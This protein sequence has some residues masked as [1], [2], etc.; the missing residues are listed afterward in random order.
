MANYTSL[1]SDLFCNSIIFWVVGGGSERERERRRVRT[2]THKVTLS[3]LFFYYL[4]HA[5]YSS[6]WMKLI[7]SQV[8]I[9]IP[10]PSTYSNSYIIL[11]PCLALIGSNDIYH[12][13]K[14]NSIC[15][16]YIYPFLRNNTLLTTWPVILWYEFQ[17]NL[18]LCSILLLLSLLIYPN[19]IEFNSE[20]YTHRVAS[21]SSSPSSTNSSTVII[22]KT[23]KT[24]Y[25]C[26]YSQY[27][28]LVA[29]PSSFTELNYEPVQNEIQLVNIQT[30]LEMLWL[31]SCVLIHAFSHE[32]LC[33]NKI[34]NL[35]CSVW[36]SKGM[37]IKL[38]LLHVNWH[39]RAIWKWGLW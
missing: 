8:S 22:T 17:M 11:S 34:Q 27:K 15:L 25:L 20:K 16:N 33:K 18:F 24:K 31:C 28:L 4:N 19:V 14:T 6:R 3:A 7:F 9:L 37:I 38:P 30:H 10:Y 12:W 2:K 35:M 39:K 23:Y 36:I 21:S 1:H 13:T 29:S 32:I 5:A 26:T